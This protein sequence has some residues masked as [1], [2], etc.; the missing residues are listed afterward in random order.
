MK[1]QYFPDTD[2]LYLTLQNQSSCESEEVSPDITLDFDAKGTVVGI[3]IDHASH[4]LDSLNVE[5]IL[6][7]AAVPVAFDLL[8]TPDPSVRGRAA[9]ALG[10][11]GQGSEAVRP[12]LGQ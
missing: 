5:T 3:T 12:A 6:A 1:V 4:Q 10:K 2:T 11:L 8:Q 7:S 9:D